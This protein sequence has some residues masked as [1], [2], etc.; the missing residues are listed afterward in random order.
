MIRPILGKDIGDLGAIYEKPFKNQYYY[1]TNNALLYS[2]Q[3][4]QDHE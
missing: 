2:T 3:L 1:D 4:L